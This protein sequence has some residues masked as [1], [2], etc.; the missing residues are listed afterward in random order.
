M[1][2]TLNENIEQAKQSPTYK[3]APNLTSECYL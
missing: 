1:E 3:R 2:N